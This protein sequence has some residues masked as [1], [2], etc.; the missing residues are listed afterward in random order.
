MK[1]FLGA[2]IPDEIVFMSGHMDSW[3]V[4]SGA[5]DDGL[6]PSLSSSPGS[7]DLVLQHLRKNRVDFACNRRTDAKV[8][9][10]EQ[11]GVFTV[12]VQI[13]PLRLPCGSSPR[14]A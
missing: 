5:M 8:F 10:V 11:T 6:H 4:G 2:E 1:C 7:V 13:A 14:S 9:F 3:D 12:D